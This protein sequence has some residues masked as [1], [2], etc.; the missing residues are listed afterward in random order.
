LAFVPVGQFIIEN[1][2]NNGPGQKR[3]HP[4]INRLGEVSHHPQNPPQKKGSGE[5]PAA[6]IVKSIPVM[7][8][9]GVV[10]AQ[11]MQR[12]GDDQSARTNLPGRML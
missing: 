4:D 12:Q 9:Q 5:D 8:P 10:D 7:Y 11:E 3:I 6:Q 1:T 2:Y